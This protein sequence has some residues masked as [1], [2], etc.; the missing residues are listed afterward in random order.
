MLKTHW[1]RILWVA[2]TV[3]LLCALV[4]QNGGWAAAHEKAMIGD[5]TSLPNEAPLPPP[6]P[7]AAPADSHRPEAAKEKPKNP[8]ADWQTILTGGGTESVTIP[9][10]AL[11]NFHYVAF[12]GDTANL[13]SGFVKALGIDADTREQLEKILQKSLDELKTEEQKNAVLVENENASHVSIKGNMQTASRLV[14]DLRKNLDQLV[15]R[16]IANVIVAAAVKS[17]VF[18]RFGTHDQE[19]SFIQDPSKENEWLFERRYSYL[20]SDNVT[21]TSSLA[22]SMS[23]DIFNKRYKD[24]WD[25]LQSKTQ[26]DR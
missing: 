19:L 25:A 26:P 17:T 11:A 13:A 12:A 20:A 16:D 21:N 4:Y 10:A 24:L 7:S 6:R 22:R 5:Y 9:T 18:S 1:E 23:D 8:E 15:G 2:I 14:G 3:L